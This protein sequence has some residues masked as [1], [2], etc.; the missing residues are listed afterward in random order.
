MGRT[1]IRNGYLHVGGDKR[2]KRRAVKIRPTY[3]KKQQKR[4]FGALAAISTQIGSQLIG[5]LI[6]KIFKKFSFP[7][8]LKLEKTHKKNL[9]KVSICK[10]CRSFKRSYRSK[11]KRCGKKKTSTRARLQKLIQKS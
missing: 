2:K 6:D 9:I 11:C 4:G 7:E 5:G 3:R 10:Y 1:V 8:Q